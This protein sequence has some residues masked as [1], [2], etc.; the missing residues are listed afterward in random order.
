MR[1]LVSYHGRRDDLAVFFAKTSLERPNIVQ[2]QGQGQ[3]K[4]RTQRCLTEFWSKRIFI[5]PCQPL[6]RPIS[7]LLVLGLSHCPLSTG[8]CDPQPTG[9]PFLSPLILCLSNSTTK[10]FL[11]SY[12]G[13]SLQ[14]RDSNSHS[15]IPL[16]HTGPCGDTSYDPPQFLP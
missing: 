1:N 14:L 10:V 7:F 6:L 15:Y 4:K 2:D 8:C 16:G 5:S 9:P 13:T 11:V 12:F 3:I